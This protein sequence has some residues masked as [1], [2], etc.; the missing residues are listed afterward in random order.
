VKCTV[1][2]V[3]NHHQMHKMWKRFYFN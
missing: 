3:L 2:S 1:V